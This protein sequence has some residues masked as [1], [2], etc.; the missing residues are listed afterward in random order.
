MKGEVEEAL[1]DGGRALRGL[2]QDR[3]PIKQIWQEDKLFVLI[4]T[5]RGEVTSWMEGGFQWNVPCA[6]NGY[7]GLLGDSRGRRRSWNKRRQGLVFLYT[8]DLEVSRSM[9]KS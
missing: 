1:Q 7:A 3:P 5:E 8:G 9:F 6:G 2:G 4:N